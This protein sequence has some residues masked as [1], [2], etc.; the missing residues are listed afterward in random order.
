MGFSRSGFLRGEKEH[1]L[2][3]ARR[4]RVHSIKRLSIKKRK[5]NIG[6]SSMKQRSQRALWREFTRS[7]VS[8]SHEGRRGFF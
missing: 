6:D 8:E 1:V 3:K 5:K 4:R 7:A 2:G